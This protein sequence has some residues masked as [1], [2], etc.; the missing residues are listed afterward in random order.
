[1]HEANLEYRICAHDLPMPLLRYDAQGRRLYMN[2]AAAAMM[3][4]G[5]DAVANLDM[6]EHC[7]DAIVKVAST[8][9][10]H[11][12]E[13]TIETGSDNE[14]R[15]LRAALWPDPAPQG[16]AA[17]VALYQDISA[18]KREEERLRDWHRTLL[19]SL[20]DMVWLTDPDG[21][22]LGC[23]EAAL[24]HIGITSET[25][26]IGRTPPEILGER[27]GSYL[28]EGDR[29]AIE[30]KCPT[31]IE[32]WHVP[33]ATGRPK[34]LE[35]RR[36]PLLAADGAVHALLSV[37]RD[38]TEL[39]RQREQIHNL[40]YYD[41]LTSLPNRTGF[42]EYLRKKTDCSTSGREMVGVMMLDMDRFK[43][44][45]DTL[46]PAMGDE[47]LCQAAERLRAV[48]RAG[49]IVARCGADEFA[50]LLPDVPER[51]ALEDI[52]R[53]IIKSF[54]D[55]FVL[56]DKEVFT[57]CS[58]GIAVYPSDSASPDELMNYADMAMYLT[59]RSGH[60]GYRFYSR[61]LAERVAERLQLEADLCYALERGEL[62]LH[63]Q[64]K[65][66]LSRQ[67]VIGSEALLRW[68]RP[69]FGLVSADQFI[70]AAEQAGLIVQLG[71]WALR[72]ACRTAAE[73]NHDGK[74]RHK[75]AVNLSAWQVQSIVLTLKNIL[76]E[77]GCRPELIELEITESL[78]LEDGESVSTTLSELKSMGF[79]IAIDDFGTGYSSLAYLSRL[80]ID[81]LKVDKSFVQNAT[82]DS[83]HATLL[84]AILAMADCL[85]QQVVAEGVET[86]QQAEF[87]RAHGCEVV[88]G[89]L[90]GMP[91]PK[92]DLAL[93]LPETPS[94]REHA[95]APGTGEPSAQE[96]A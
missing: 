59:K 29:V 87:L 13:L 93:M 60:C 41:A 55:R 6:R 54:E 57:P 68:R 62:E 86:M 7:R 70:S 4:K 37:A 23:N 16:Q 45:N 74:M 34:L 61:D 47:L 80:P 63:Y 92:Q 46:G 22:Y 77:T 52:A 28:L 36:V 73:W 14:S 67:E 96:P 78:L 2:A 72:E 35:L 43:D 15:H 42:N 66:A 19:N 17:V 79:T 83:R 3:G 84:K 88:Q 56:G 81:V 65:V 95:R 18:Y 91:M 24:H 1:M 89:L 44:V 58:I 12:L 33:R 75:V 64:P 5:D 26:V 50:V 48:V 31:T 10:P 39:Y 27:V 25:D 85:G 49:D 94:H 90:F 71:T 53:R 76:D 38:V 30:N 69:G 21:R 8:G 9:T 82:K 11:E 32:S 20:P 51:A 40:A